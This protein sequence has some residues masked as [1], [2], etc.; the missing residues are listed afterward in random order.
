MELFIKNNVRHREYA[1]ISELGKYYIFGQTQIDSIKDTNLLIYLSLQNN[2]IRCKEGHK[3]AGLSWS[4]RRARGVCLRCGKLS[5]VYELFGTVKNGHYVDLDNIKARSSHK[6]EDRVLTCN[7]NIVYGH[8]IVRL[9]NSC[10]KK[11]YAIKHDKGIYVRYY[12][13]NRYDLYTTDTSKDYHNLSVHRLSINTV[14]DII[15]LLFNPLFPIKLYFCVL[16]GDYWD[17]YDECCS[18]CKI[19]C[20]KIITRFSTIIHLCFSNILPPELS[21]HIIMLMWSS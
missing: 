14:S 11:I 3:R 9:C 1:V 2:P 10:K 6:C 12:K 13:E 4:K 18:R 21:H 5:L 16:C 8:E 20:V 17:K 7:V 15:K 19:E